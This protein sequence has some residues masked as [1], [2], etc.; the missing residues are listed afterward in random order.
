MELSQ[1]YTSLQQ[2][3]SLNRDFKLVEVTDRI[4]KK[5]LAFKASYPGLG[6]EEI[7]SGDV[8]VPSS[9][10]KNLRDI[11][12]VGCRGRMVADEERPEINRINSLNLVAPL[13]TTL[14][15]LSAYLG[16]Q[17]DFI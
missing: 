7:M 9:M 4:E 1:L 16:S 2:T 10:R 15:K 13:L 6:T 11:V 17:D 5:L 14:P 8:D 3:S 12:R